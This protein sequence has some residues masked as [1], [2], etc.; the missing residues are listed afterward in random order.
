M[1]TYTALVNGDLCIYDLKLRIGVNIVL[2]QRQFVSFHGISKTVVA[3]LLR[4]KRKGS[5]VLGKKVETSGTP[6]HST[7]T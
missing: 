3:F 1:K 5:V 7:K 6:T 2:L 4:K